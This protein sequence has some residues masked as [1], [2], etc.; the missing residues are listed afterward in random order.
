[1]ALRNLKNQNSFVRQSREVVFASHCTASD[2]SE[3]VL[4]HARFRPCGGARIE[5]FSCSV[6][7]T[8]MIAS[9][10][11]LQVMSSTRQLWAVVVAAVWVSSQVH[12]H[13]C[14]CVSPCLSIAL[15]CHVSSEKR[16]R[17]RK[18]RTQEVWTHPRATC[19]STTCLQ[20]R[21]RASTR[22]PT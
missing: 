17:I 9:I 7:E 20:R 6:A 18:V 2:V 21:H 16:I 12:A 22:L 11:E 15:L 10:R 14:L 3:A 8:Q 13:L 19:A 4:N 5:T 1:M